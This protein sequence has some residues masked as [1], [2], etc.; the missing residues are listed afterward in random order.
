METLRFTN[1]LSRGAQADV[2]TS[3]CL[4]LLEAKDRKVVVL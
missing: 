2:H 3:L 1:A 4:S